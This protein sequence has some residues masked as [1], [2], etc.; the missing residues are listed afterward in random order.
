MNPDHS[1]GL[2]RCPA[3]KEVLAREEDGSLRCRRAG[4]GQGYL[5]S[6]RGE[7]SMAVSTDDI[8][9]ISDRLPRA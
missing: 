7:V 4:C 8:V 5:K 2:P 9:V 6:H 3:C 1:R